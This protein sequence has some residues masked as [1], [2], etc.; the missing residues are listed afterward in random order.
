MEEAQQYS[1]TE[2]HLKVFEKSW[3]LRSKI[4][5]VLQFVGRLDGKQGL[6]IGGLG[7]GLSRALRKAGGSWRSADVFARGVQAL[8]A[9]VGDEVDLLEDGKLPYPDES[10]DL[11]VVSERLEMVEDDYTFIVECH[12][13]LKSSGRL[14]VMTPN[15]QKV[16]P[17]DGVEIGVKRGFDEKH[18]YE[19]LHAQFA[20]QHLD[21]GLRFR[22]LVK[23]LA[24]LASLIIGQDWKRKLPGMENL[25]SQKT[26][27]WRD[28]EDQF[29]SKIH[30]TKHMIIAIGRSQ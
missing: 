29:S 3:P 17:A 11:V 18:L 30:L 21:L 16:R 28:R 12:R 4:R 20:Q 8:Q 6:D 24:V 13:V 5:H 25:K 2:T 1:P 7:G 27:M 23:K 10:F 15:T 19:L 14:I 22:I 26:K 9:M